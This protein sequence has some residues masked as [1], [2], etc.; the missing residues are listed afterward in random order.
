MDEQTLQ[1]IAAQLRQ[2]HGEDAVH[3]GVKMNE[4]NLHINRYT[5]EALQAQPG[6]HILEI[7]MGNGMFVRELFALQNDIRYTGL[8]ASDVMVHEARLHNETFITNGQA[9]FQEGH[10]EDLSFQ[11]HLFDKI[12]SINTIYFWDDLPA[13]LSEI[14]RVLKPK[15]QLFIAVRPKYLMENYPFVRYGFNLFSRE[16]LAALLSANRFSVKEVVEKD[17]PEHLINGEKIVVA[18]LIVRAEK[19]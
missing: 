5:L 19:E 9:E 3:V 17:E 18:T 14:G 4:G 11:D 12:F 8:D 13:A 7:G 6:N 10:V 15:G 1:S 16:D 2:P